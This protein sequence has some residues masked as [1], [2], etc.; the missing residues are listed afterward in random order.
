MRLTDPEL[1]IKEW[2]QEAVRRARQTFPPLTM[3][4]RG[5]AFAA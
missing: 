1:A 4:L 2:R 3:V 5:R